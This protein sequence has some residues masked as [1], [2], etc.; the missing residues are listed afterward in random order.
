M[1][2]PN[3]VFVKGEGWVPVSYES[4]TIV[5]RTGQTVRYELREPK[6]GEIFM[7]CNDPWNAK[8]WGEW[9]YQSSHVFKN[10]ESHRYPRKEIKPGSSLC[11][12]IWE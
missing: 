11:V 6:E 10:S 2:E 8:R 7:H 3:Y 1:T 5:N 12:M 4:H 9:V